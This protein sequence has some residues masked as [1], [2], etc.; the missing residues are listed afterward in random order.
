MYI[1]ALFLFLPVM[2]AQALDIHI[3]VRTRRTSN[4]S[5]PLNPQDFLARY[6]YMS[7]KHRSAEDMVEAIKLMQSFYHIPITGVLDNK[8]LEMMSKPRCGC[9]DIQPPTTRLPLMPD[10]PAAYTLGPAWKTKHLTWTIYRYYYNTR[11]ITERDQKDAMDRAFKE[12]AKYAPLFFTYVDKDA[13]LTIG[14]HQGDHND[15]SDFDG[16]GTNLAHAYDPP[17]GRIHFDSEEDWVLSSNDGTELFT[18]AAH[19]IGHALGLG[20]S[21]VE[22]SLMGPVYTGFDE[23]FELHAD[24]IRGIQLLYGRRQTSRTTASL[25]INPTNKPV[26]ACDTNFD[27]TVRGH[28]E[29]LYAFHGKK[30]YKIGDTGLMREDSID[31]VFPGAPYNIDAAFR[32]PR[33]RQVVLL[34]GARMWLFNWFTLDPSYPNI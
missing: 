27:A 22:Y 1:Q 19:E 8:T 9:P 13:D 17:D 2:A 3:P 16:R 4:D 5:K 29:Y 14:F 15:G 12:W 18:V 20:H 34:K 21:T 11:K 10:N 33:T 25:P 30:V 24:D 32:H 31:R 26:E 7:Q 6:G 28:D 23:E